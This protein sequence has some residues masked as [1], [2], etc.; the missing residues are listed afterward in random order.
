LLA[1]TMEALVRRTPL[2]SK[3]QSQTIL[4]AVCRLPI[5]VASG[6]RATGGDKL[7]QA[8]SERVAA[9]LPPGVD[10]LTDAH[11]IYI[12][13]YVTFLESLGVSHG[14]ARESA[15]QSWNPASGGF[16]QQYVTQYINKQTRSHGLLA[17]TKDTLE[18]IA[19]SVIE[20]LKLP[21]KRRCL[22][23]AISVWPDND[24]IL[25]TRDQHSV[26]RAVGILSCKTSL[27]ERTFES[28]FWTLATRDTGL[29]SGFVTADLDNELGQCG[30]TGK[31]RQIAETYFDRTYSTNPGTAWCSQVRPFAEIGEEMLRWQSD[32]V[33]RP[34]KD[35]V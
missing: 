23:S 19:P 34:M 33:V 6:K 25:L 17:C 22:Q 32:V 2:L 29:R 12:E 35:P 28:A 31:T 8:I 16:F 10:P 27:R 13:A 20:F 9:F 30:G 11:A 15:R 7:L 4:S 5:L 14:T 3:N 1:L 24:I 21:A 26:W 18:S